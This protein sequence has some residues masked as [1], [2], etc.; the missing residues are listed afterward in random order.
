MATVNR[1]SWK[2][3]AI[4]FAL[5]SIILSASLVVAVWNRPSPSEQGDA[6]RF[7]F[8]V[9]ASGNVTQTKILIDKV[10]DFT[11]LIVFTNLEF[12]KN[13]TSLIEMADYAASKGLNF[14]VHITYPSPFDKNFTYNPATWLSEAQ[15]RYG[16]RFLGYYLWDEPGG[17]QLDRGNFRQFDNTSMPLDYREAANTFI[18]YLYIQ[19]RDF[20]KA[21]LFTSDYALEWFDYEAGYDVVLTQFGWNNSRPLNIAVCRG[22][23]EMHNKTWGAMVTWTFDHTPYIESPNEMYQDLVTAYSAGAKYAVVFNYPNNI[24]DYGLLTEAH[25]DALKNFKKYIS[26]N[27]Q[28]KTSNTNR[29]AYVMPENY[30]WGL[31]NPDDT[32]WGVWQADNKSQTVWSGLNGMIQAYGDDFDV[33]YDS[34]WTKLFGRYHY[35]NLIWW[36]ATK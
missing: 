15:N 30:G 32:I 26:E 14:L 2:H 3:A 4:V 8:G 25:F 20:I 34:P 24:T 12:T 17:N 35:Q 18:Y 11:N 33:V 23:A 36:N 22:A 29:V 27:A 19:M 10:K 13:Q 9:T 1:V 7:Y 6:P 16:N 28:N 21:P 5:L 31:R